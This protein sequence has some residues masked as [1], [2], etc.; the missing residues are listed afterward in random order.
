M[1]RTL[2][3]GRLEEEEEGVINLTAVYP[4]KFLR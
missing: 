1:D 4:G 2:K 3:E